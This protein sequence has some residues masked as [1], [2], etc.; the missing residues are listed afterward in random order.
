MMAW[1]RI[2]VDGRLAERSAGAFGQGTDGGLQWLWSCEMRG[3][4]E[5]HGKQGLSRTGAGASLRGRWVG[6]R[7]SGRTGCRQAGSG[8]AAAIGPRRTIELGFPRPA[9]WQ[10][11]CEVAC[12]AGDPSGQGEEPPPEGPW[13]SWSC[14]PRPIRAL[15]SGRGC[16][17]I[18]CTASQGG[19]GGEA[20]RGDDGSTPHRA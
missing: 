13:W 2:W 12:R 16:A 15:S 20:A 3:D 17:A 5:R 8:R 1:A 9:L 18:T 4:G 14:S 10:M 7:V 6:W 11:Q 19:V